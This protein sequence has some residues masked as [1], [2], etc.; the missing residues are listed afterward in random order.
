M[1]DIDKKPKLEVVQT[2]PDALDLSG[3]WHATCARSKK[4]LREVHPPQQPQTQRL[5]GTPAR[6]ARSKQ[7]FS[8]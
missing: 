7:A 8:R 4:P 2:P 5:L 6:S 3:L 1:A